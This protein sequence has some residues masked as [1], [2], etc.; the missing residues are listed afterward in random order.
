MEISS[1]KG[2]VKAS[3]QTTDLMRSRQAQ[4]KDHPVQESEQHLE[5]SDLSHMI[6]NFCVE[7]HLISSFDR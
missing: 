3:P 7:A 5:T 1:F 4:R 2:S 6:N